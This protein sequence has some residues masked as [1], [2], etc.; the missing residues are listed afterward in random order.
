M[1]LENYIKI[2]KENIG[3]PRI[4]KELESS[5]A[6]NKSIEDVS[7][8]RRVA[9]SSLNRNWMNFISAEV[10]KETFIQNVNQTLNQTRSEAQ[11]SLLSK[12]DEEKSKLRK[13]I[14]T[15]IDDVSKLALIYSVIENTFSNL[16]NTSSESLSEAFATHQQQ[17]AAQLQEQS[18][19]TYLP[20]FNTTDEVDL[21]ASGLGPVLI[22]AD[23]VIVK[24]L[25]KVVEDTKKLI[26]EFLPSSEYINDVTNQAITE[27][28]ADKMPNLIAQEVMSIMKTW[29]EAQFGLLDSLLTSKQVKREILM[30]NFREI[31]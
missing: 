23:Q 19:G 26:D 5:Q 27:R 3:F 13:Y 30:T 31:K 7:A 9:T 22:Q 16:V 12:I 17:L 29:Q 8:I 25:D 4:V 15:N 20:N 2:I 24:T 21:L 6:Y 10:A 28:L 11:K 1:G 18:L 14:A